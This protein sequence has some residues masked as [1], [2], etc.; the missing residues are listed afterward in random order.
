MHYKRLYG[1]K[2]VLKETVRTKKKKNCALQGAIY[3]IYNNKTCT[4]SAAV[5]REREKNVY[6][7]RLY[8]DK[9]VLKAT[10]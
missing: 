2:L 5:W 1:D 6:C 7:K 10:V 4:T 9:C 8:G 3:Y